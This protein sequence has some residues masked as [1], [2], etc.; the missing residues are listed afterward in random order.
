MTTAERLEAVRDAIDAIVLGE[1]ASSSIDGVSYT[2]LDID[3]LQ[4]L[5]TVLERRLDRESGRT[6]RVSVA[7]FGG[8]R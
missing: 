1:V 6:R 8:C 3:K 5:E 4:K 7:N 2:K